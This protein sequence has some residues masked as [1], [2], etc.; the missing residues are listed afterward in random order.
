MSKIKLFPCMVFDA[1]CFLEYNNS[2]HWRPDQRAFREKIDIL[3]SGKL[4]N[5][6]IGMGDL[7][8]R[9]SSYD[10]NGKFWNYTLDD[11]A[12]LFSNFEFIQ[13]ELLEGKVWIS[14]VDYSHEEWMEKYLCYINILKEIKFD[15]LWESDLLPI[16]QE[17]INKRQEKYKHYNFGDVFSDIRK[18]KQC[19]P[20]EDVKIFITVMSCPVSFKLYGNS[21]LDHIGNLEY[22][23]SNIENTRIDIIYHE[24]M[25]GF[26]NYELECLYLEYINNID[27]LKKQYDIL[28]NEM[29][30]G[31]EEEMV[32]AAEYYLR[33][34][35]NNENK[36]ELLKEARNR[37]N[38]CMPTS[39]FLF[40][41]LSKE[42]ETP[43]GYSKWLIDVFRS[44]RLPENEIKYNLDNIFK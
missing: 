21:F 18:L 27:Y 6:Y 12:K 44:K 23:Y 9:I 19:E 14:N 3:T 4:N 17:E 38:G 35:H 42:V 16:I 1:V 36:I 30:S 31:N 7:C 22:Y 2:D 20:L 40:D 29:D 34:K 32:V 37:Y 15:K 41:L 11:L 24:L 33:M 28:I 8:N 5:G 39:V 10:K 13:K 25:H 43:S 26:S